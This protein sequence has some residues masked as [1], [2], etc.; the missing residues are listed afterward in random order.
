MTFLIC[1]VQTIG[2]AE[3][4]PGQLC[5]PVTS[6]ISV[7]LLSVYSWCQQY[8]DLRRSK[9]VVSGQVTEQE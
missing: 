8:A 5:S 9:E 1:G 6:S 4:S 3:L 2:S 7:S